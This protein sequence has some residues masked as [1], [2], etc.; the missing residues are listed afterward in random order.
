[1]TGS[2]EAHPVRYSPD[3]SLALSPPDIPCEEEVDQFLAGAEIGLEQSLDSIR[4]VN[5]TVLGS[6]VEN[7]ERTL[8]WNMTALCFD[9]GCFV[10][11]KQG[12]RVKF[13]GKSNCLTL[14]QTEHGWNA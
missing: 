3:A 2:L 8:N 12:I 9:T 7:P 1:M 14:T 4:H 6:K 11:D 13:F 5:E 10:I